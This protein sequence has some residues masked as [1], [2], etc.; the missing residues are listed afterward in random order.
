MAASEFI[1]HRRSS[2]QGPHTSSTKQMFI[3]PCRFTVNDS[4]H[5]ARPS[6]FRFRYTFTMLFMVIERFKQ[7]NPQAVGARF[8]TRGRMLPEGVTYQAS[9]MEG[10]GSRCYQI[11]EAPNREALNPWIHS[12]QD[13]VDF[14]IVPVLTSAE[15]WSHRSNESGNPSVPA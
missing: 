5:R 9:W 8:H 7:G 14:E 12:W 10:T 13:L 11:M 2:P 6:H 4:H 1:L 15:F 3:T